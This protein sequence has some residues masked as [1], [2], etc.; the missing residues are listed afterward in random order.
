M[1]NYINFDNTAKFL[2]FIFPIL[3][4]SGPF[5]SDLAVIIIDLW[6]INKLINFKEIRNQYIKN[7]IFY[8]FL[9]FNLLFLLSTIFS[10]YF[11]N[12]IKSSLF[13]FRFY[14]FAFAVYFILDS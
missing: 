14:L 5:L 9:I 1:K 7:K 10:D 12:S 2:F 11:L 13:Y 4:I 6:F 8:F 3:I